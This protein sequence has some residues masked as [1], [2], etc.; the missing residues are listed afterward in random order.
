MDDVALRTPDEAGSDAIRPRVRGAH[1]APKGSKP[2]KL[3]RSER[4]AQAKA[5]ADAAPNGSSNGSSNGSGGGSG[6]KATSGRHRRILPDRPFWQELP[7][8]LVVAVVVAYIVKTFL[9]QVFFIPSGSMENTLRIN[10]R[11]LVDKL[12]FDLRD[13]KRG[14]ILVFNAEGVLAPEGSV[15]AEPTNPVARTFRS[16]TSAIGLAPSNETDYI[17]R[18]IG[19]PGDRVKCCDAQGRMS[20][21][22]VPL[23]ESSYLFPGDVPSTSQFDV[24]VPEGK[25]WVMGDHRSASADSRSRIGAPGGGFVP[26]DRVVGRAFVVSWPFENIKR[27]SIPDTFKQSLIEE[28]QGT[29]Q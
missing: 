13:I 27:L 15:V 20:I 28:Q 23:E 12:S 10:D 2:E 3:S 19:L 17:K 5:R 4:R 29:S 1:A 21:N 9:L 7:I 25:L 22:D 6:K 8:L 14:E 18:V 11:V 16:F 26:I 24:V